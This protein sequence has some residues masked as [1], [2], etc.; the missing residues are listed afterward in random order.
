[1]YRKYIFLSC[2]KAT[3]LLCKKAE[4]DL[5]VHEAIRLRFHLIF[6]KSCTRFAKQIVFLEDKL[7]DLLQ[8]REEFKLSP[9]KKAE[10][11]QKIDES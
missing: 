3:L 4:T 11:Q 10:I 6:C 1:M 5:T 7:T 9:F 8:N 2:E